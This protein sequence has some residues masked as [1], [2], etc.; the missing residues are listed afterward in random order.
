M[1]ARS[2][3]VGL[4]FYTLCCRDDEEDDGHEDDDGEHAPPAVTPERDKAAK[5]T[6]MWTIGD[7]E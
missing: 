1:L 4:L 2:N 3:H 7:N 6:K 5:K